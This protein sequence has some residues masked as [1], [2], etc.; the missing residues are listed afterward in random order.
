MRLDIYHHS[1]PAH[2][3][4]RARLDTIAIQ[5]KELIMTTQAEL[6]AQLDTVA[7]HQQKTIDE[8]GVVKMTLSELAAQ[9]VLLQEQL[10]NAGTVTDDL[11]ASAQTVLDLAMR[12]DAELPDIQVTP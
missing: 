1:D 6:K 4:L 10:N 2:S 5:L 3:D 11:K 12:A 9:I 8:I 7:V